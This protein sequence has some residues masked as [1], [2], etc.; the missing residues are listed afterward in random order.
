MR[1]F[2]SALDADALR[3]RDGGD[4]LGFRA[5]ATRLARQLAPGLTQATH[6]VRGFSLLCLGLDIVARAS[7]KGATLP[8]D[9]V[10]QRFERLWVLS[11]L[12]R[13][14]A[15]AK[16][17]PGV[18]KARVILQAGDGRPSLTTPLLARQL[19]GGLWGNYRRSSGLF[20]LIRTSRRHASV[21]DSELTALGR[22]LADAA[23]AAIAPGFRFVSFVHKDEISTTELMRLRGA[24]APSTA[25]HRLVA[26]AMGEFDQA[27]N[28]A[29]AAL[30]AI[31]KR[32]RSLDL[33]LLAT[34]RNE[35]TDEQQDALDSAIELDWLMERLEKP[36]RH[37]VS[38]G[39]PNAPPIAKIADR[40]WNRVAGLDR[41]LASLR[42]RLQGSASMQSLHAHQEWLARV[43]GAPAWALGDAT[44]SI[45]R[46]IPPDFGLSSPSQLFAQGLRL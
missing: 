24:I 15:Q 6:L 7:A 20:G 42:E 27:Y 16:R 44:P 46:Y 9:E 8:R 38:S 28:G 33:S 22:K 12:A 43:R 37:W 40:R 10:F 35:L 1:L 34:F 32:Y 5:L 2:W 14:P 18:R 19:A 36:Y 30:C 11:V 25:E 26:E 29:L 3:V 13:S 4:P 41:Y 17:F 31:W 39:S 23:Q 45:A 21:S